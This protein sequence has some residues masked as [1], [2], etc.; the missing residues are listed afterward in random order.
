MGQYEYIKGESITPEMI[1][2]TFKISSSKKINRVLDQP[3]KYVLIFEDTK[4]RGSNRDIE[5]IPDRL[6]I[7]SYKKIIYSDFIEFPLEHFTNLIDRIKQIYPHIYN[8]VIGED[9]KSVKIKPSCNITNTNAT[10]VQRIEVSMIEVEEIQDYLLDPKNAIGLD[11]FVLAELIRKFYIGE[12]DYIGGFVIQKQILKYVKALLE[13][14]VNAEYI[15]NKV[16]ENPSIVDNDNFFKGADDKKYFMV[17]KNEILKT[18]KTGLYKEA[19]DLK[20]LSALS[21]I[22]DV[23]NDKRF[24]RR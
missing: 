5:V 22:G 17:F 13:E 15:I 12:K 18:T 24:G 9:I 2:E 19:L 6:F 21:V 1:H 20:F 7:S 16:T 14:Q 3:I 11:I 23:L 4:F 10:G 8:F